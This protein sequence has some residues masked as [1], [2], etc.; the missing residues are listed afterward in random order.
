MLQ[1][2]AM[3][4][5]HSH[6]SRCLAGFVVLSVLAFMQSA[7]LAAPPQ[8]SSDEL[9][10]PLYTPPKKLAPRARVGGDVRGTEGTD[11][12][13][14]LLVPE[15]GLPYEMIDRRDRFK[16]KLFQRLN[17]LGSIPSISRNL[18]WSWNRMSNIDYLYP[19]FGMPSHLRKIL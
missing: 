1:S 19:S 15:S 18:A 4:L 16:K 14:I 3:S 11:P 13:V 9:S 5:L 17:S 7:L 6:V 12:V 10:Q 8:K 2:S